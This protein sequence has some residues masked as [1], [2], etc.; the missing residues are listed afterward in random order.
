MIPMPAISEKE[1]PVIPSA[2]VMGISLAGRIK[3]AGKIRIVK[4]LREKR[5]I[6]KR[7]TAITEVKAERTGQPHS[8]CF[9]MLQINFHRENRRTAC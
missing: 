4:R 7:I 5:K 1:T 2:S 3:Q 6:L 8:G 9:P